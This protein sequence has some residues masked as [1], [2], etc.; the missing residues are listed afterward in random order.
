MIKHDIKVIIYG[1]GYCSYKTQITKNFTGF[2]KAKCAMENRSITTAIYK[3]S[4]K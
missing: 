3:R 2:E 1:Y 4:Y